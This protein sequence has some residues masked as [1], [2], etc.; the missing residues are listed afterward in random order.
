MRCKT[1]QHLPSG[2][3]SYS[4]RE[5][6]LLPYTRSEQ[7]GCGMPRDSVVGLSDNGSLTFHP[8]SYKPHGLQATPDVPLS[9]QHDSATRFLPYSSDLPY[10]RC[11]LCLAWVSP[12]DRRTLTL[13]DTT[14]ASPVVS[15]AVLNS[16][17]NS[18][19][20][21]KLCKG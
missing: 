3:F 6:D 21:A 12:F 17:H 11:S 14:K 1:V 9:I 5:L 16:R 18:T 20:Q 19:I 10:L 2:I 15:L 7:S 13:S 4:S 8:F